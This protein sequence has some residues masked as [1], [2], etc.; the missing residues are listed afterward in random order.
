MKR[1]LILSLFLNLL[2]FA[3]IGFALHRLGGWRYAWLRLQHQT[4][5]LYHHRVQHFERLDEQTGSIIFLGDSQTEQA[6]W[7]EL[8]GDRPAVLNRGVSGDFTRGVLDR[9]DEVLRH[10]PLKIFLLIGINDLIF[11]NDI[12][13]IEVTYRNIV[14]NIR[15]QSPDTELF[16]LSVLPVNNQLR[17]S[18]A[19]NQTIEALNARIRQI[20]RD[21]ALPYLDIATPLKDADGQLAAK[22]SEDGLHLNGLGYAVWK[23]EIDGMINPD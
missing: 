1:L 17:R 15:T 8:F 12:A 23:K 21:F 3:A 7:H 11:G 5:G 13:E 4:A 6:E 19:D 2:L 18:G 22:F 14:Q 20:A 10:K 9:L 16:L